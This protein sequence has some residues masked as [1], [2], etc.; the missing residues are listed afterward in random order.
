MPHHVLSAPAKDHRDTRTTPVTRLDV[1][2]GDVVHI[3]GEDRRYR[4]DPVTMTVTR[5]RDDLM[6]CYDNIWVWIE[7]YQV[8]SDRTD[9]PW[10]Q[11]LARVTSLYGV[12]G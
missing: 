1:G 4:P 11:V 12:R 2:P 3:A 6:G 5:V 10:I 8:L 7:G 9:G